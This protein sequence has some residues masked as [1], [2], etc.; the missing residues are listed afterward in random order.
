M[1]FQKDGTIISEPNPNNYNVW[2]R[3]GFVEVDE[4][5]EEVKKPRAKAK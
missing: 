2:I 3:E 5:E 4:E 1:L